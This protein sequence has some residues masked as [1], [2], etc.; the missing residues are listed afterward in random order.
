MNV[1]LM[2]P[3]LLTMNAAYEGGGDSG[4]RCGVRADL[5]AHR[6][7]GGG[8]DGRNDPGQFSGCAHGPGRRVGVVIR[9]CLH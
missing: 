2:S 7:S 1:M 3:K 5:C 8:G 6:G 9:V 4:R